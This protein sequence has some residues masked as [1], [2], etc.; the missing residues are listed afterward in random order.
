MYTQIESQN[1]N[2][3][4]NRLNNKRPKDHYTKI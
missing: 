4:F 1:W 2:Y 3:D